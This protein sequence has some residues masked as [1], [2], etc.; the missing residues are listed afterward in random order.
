MAE[1]KTKAAIAS[2]APSDKAAVAPRVSETYWQLVFRQ[3]G[4]SR[5]NRLA[6][7]GVVVLIFVAIF[8][9]F[10]ASDKPIYV[11]M[12]GESYLLPNVFDPPELRIFDN[13][14]LMDAMEEGD[15]ALLPMVPYGYNTHDLKNVLKGPSPEHWLGTD[16]SGRDVLAR[17]IHGARVSLAVG[18]LS[19][20]VLCFIGILLG[21]AAGYFGGF[22]DSAVNR[23]IEVVLS[24]PSLLLIVTMIGVINPQGWGAVFTM[25]IV[26]GLINWTGVARLIRGEILRIKSLDYIEAARALGMN[27][28][29]IIARHVIPNAISPVLVAATFAM[30]SAILIEGAL[31]F[32]GFGIPPDM[33]SWGGLLNGVRG[34]TGAWWLAVFPGLAIFLTVTAYNLAGE[35]LRDAIDPRLKA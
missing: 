6:L 30:A 10:F 31:S 25:M 28:P 20:A 4:K 1:D 34:N 5:L 15:F 11:R 33:A 27:H 19:V 3:F 22:I 17:M 13:Q 14:T 32:L 9:D 7:V 35:G 8:A 18:F 29:R 23:V 2:S 12:G 16:P 21:S 26:I 24:I